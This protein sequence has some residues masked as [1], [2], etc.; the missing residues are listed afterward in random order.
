VAALKQVGQSDIRP[1]FAQQSIREMQ[2]TNRTPRNVL[3]D[4]TWGA[5]EAGWT[6]PM[7]ADADHLKTL[8]D[9]DHCAAAG[10][11]FYTIDPGDSVDSSAEKADPATLQAK[12]EALDWSSLDANLASFLT[13]YRNHRID[14]EDEAIILED[15]ALLRAIAK[16]GPALVRFM[17]MYRH[18]DSLGIDFELELAVD[19]TDYPTTPA[20]HVVI[21]SE[22][23]RL[24]VHPVSLSPR[25]VGG[26]EKGIEYIGDLGELRRDFQLHAAIAKALGPYKLSLHSGSDKYSTYPLLMETT[27]GL[28]HMKTAGTSWAEALRII[29]RHDPALFR[30]IF[31]LA[32]QLF[33]ENRQSYPLTCD[34]TRIPVD[35]SDDQ[36]EALLD[37]TDSRQVLHVSYG[38]ALAAYHGQLYANWLGN[39]AEFRE[40]LTAHFIRHVAPF[41]H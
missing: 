2:R 4:V 38:P 16:Y 26:F 22:L 40:I 30:E 8:A 20:E 17:E 23:K 28:L 21:I 19:E 6:D 18:L 15:E 24:G 41:T 5:F 35:P 12:A 31:E 29:A 25:F 3:D 13:R 37:A 1:I 14:L 7:G 39:L 36:L 33:E 11:I 9:I 32:M 34:P 27:G 10:F